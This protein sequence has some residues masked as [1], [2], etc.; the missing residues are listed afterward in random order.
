M[1]RSAE[2]ARRAREELEGLHEELRLANEGLERRMTQMQRLN[3][4][5]RVLSGMK[6]DLLAN[7]SHELQTPL[8]SIKGFTEMILKGQLGGVT[9]EQ[10][11][12]LQLALRNVNRLIAMIENLMAFAR[13]QGP[14]TTPR[15]AVFPLAEAVEEAA[16]T[17][18]DAASQRGIG[19]R[20]ELPPGGLSVRADRDGVAQVLL[21]LIGNAVK[22]NRQGGSVTVRA[23]RGRRGNARVEVR[24]TGIGIP[25]ADLERVFDRSFRASNAPGDV[26]GTGIG[27][28]L[29]RD[30][31]RRHG[32]VIR[33]ESEEGK[34]SVFSFTLPLE[35]PQGDDGPPP[36]KAEPRRRR[37]R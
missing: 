28:A 12:G 8:V 27:L 9:P 37:R 22:Y 6:T 21:N 32:C 23:T 29:V 19:L 17:V 14:E 4:D 3:D 34:G 5:L 36:R 24:D 31:L 15:L 11:Q 20:I 18:R 2:E 10:E 35:T 16:A 25:R 13:S 7:V 26:A 30:I 1:R 33:A